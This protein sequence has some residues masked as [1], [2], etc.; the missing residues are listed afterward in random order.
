MSRY[1][2]TPN[3]L[4][5]T[6]GFIISLTTIFCILVVLLLVIYLKRR[7]WSIQMTTNILFAF[8]SIFHC[9][10]TSIPL[11]QAGIICDLSSS[12]HESTLIVMSTFIDY[13]VFYAYIS[14]DKPIL[15]QQYRWIFVHGM[16]ILFIIIFIFCS[17]IFVIFGK[18]LYNP[19]LLQCRIENKGIQIFLIA[20]CAVMGLIAIGLLFL[21]IV[22]VFMYYRK[23][24]SNDYRIKHF[25]YKMILYGIGL[26]FVVLSFIFFLVKENVGSFGWIFTAKLIE[27]AL[28]IVELFIFSYNQRL[29]F[30]F[31]ELCCCANKKRSDSTIR[32]TIE[33]ET[34]FEQ[35]RLT[36]KE[37]EQ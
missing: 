16:L 11:Y 19:D 2:F 18:N 35:E 32:S 8:F 3:D 33:F 21:L 12:F 23:D 17:I 26:L 36:Q 34:D 6:Y 29:L 13:I 30:E 37:D 10:V 25:I 27:C 24:T 20:Y 22:R 7:E 31:K 9:I 15:V 14:F 28:G 4:Y 1:I 5:L